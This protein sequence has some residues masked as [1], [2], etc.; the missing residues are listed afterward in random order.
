MLKLYFYSLSIEPDMFLL[1]LTII[2]EILNISKAYKKFG[3]IIKYIK[4]C[5]LNTEWRT[6]N[7]PAVS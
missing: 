1:I 5:T 4:L 7:R 6:K 3:W 2:R